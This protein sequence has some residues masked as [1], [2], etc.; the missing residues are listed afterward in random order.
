MA[1]KPRVKAPK[2]AAAGEIVTI[3]TLVRHNMETGQ[4]KDSDGN[5][6]PRDIIHTFVCTV[7]GKEALRSKW[8]SAVSANPYLAFPLKIMETSEVVFSWTDDQGETVSTTK[9]ITVA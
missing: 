7:N 5:K 8:E 1:A 9:T 3:K 6:I 4:R 2:K